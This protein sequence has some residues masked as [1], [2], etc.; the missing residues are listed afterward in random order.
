MSDFNS[1]KALMFALTVTRLTTGLLFIYAL[2][3]VLTKPT[4]DA[5]GSPTPITS[6]VVAHRQPRRPLIL[7][8]LFFITFTYLL[9]GLITFI[10][11][12]AWKNCTSHLIEWRGVELANALGFLAFA[13]LITIGLWKDK[14]GVDI[15]SRKRLKAFAVIAIAFD[16]AYL[17]LLLLSVR[18]FK[19][20]PEEPGIPERGHIP[21]LDIPN[22]LHFLAIDARI[23]ALLILIIV[24]FK[25]ST[26][27]STVA[28]G[29]AA[30]PTPATGLIPASGGVTLHNQ[31]AYGTFSDPEAAPKDAA[32]HNGGGATHPAGYK[33]G[34]AYDADAST[35]EGSSQQHHYN[36]PVVASEI[37]E[38]PEAATDVIHI[39]KDPEVED[40]PNPVTS[41]PDALKTSYAAVAAAHADKER[42]ADDEEG[43]GDVTIASIDAHGAES[44]NAFAFP[45]RNADD[46][47][48]MR[49]SMRGVTFKDNGDNT[50]IT[51]RQD[52]N[53]EGAEGAEKKRRR[54]SSQN[55]K[56]MVK[57]ISDLPKRQGSISS[58]GSAAKA[59][60]SS[61]ARV[62]REDSRMSGEGSLLNY[63][64]TEDSPAG[65]V[66]EDGKVQKRKRR[67]SLSLRGKSSS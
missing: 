47:S 49:G 3:L 16:I 4:Q 29:L 11:C 43:G 55:I 34:E 28:R 15:W 23:L 53:G 51:G 41:D 64:A 65:S 24:L 12:V 27:Y 60:G 6:V 22:F 50:S 46:R 25:P 36:K 20:S 33:P 44:P 32:K 30:S 56:R 37:V 31:G 21:G 54:I 52:T 26:S 48:S 10:P 63:G 9:D 39:A 59:E 17:V 58:L 42:K 40:V 67:M 45:S 18:I 62:S 8:L 66:G 5:P 19:K 61:R 14:R 1:S 7:T 35:A 2:G 57:K 13:I 38:E